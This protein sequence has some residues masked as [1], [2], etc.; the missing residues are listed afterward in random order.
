[1]SPIAEGEVWAYR[2]GRGFMEEVT[3]LKVVSQ[4][5]NSRVRIQFEDGPNAGQT[6]WVSRRMLK[7]RW[8]GKEDF[9]AREQRWEEARNQAA[10]AS[11]HELDAASL[12]LE[13]AL[14]RAIA[15]DH[16]HGILSVRN[17]SALLRTLESAEELP[18][19]AGF[20]E[21]GTLYLPWPAMRVVAQSYAQAKPDRILRE[22]EEQS[23]AWDE[24]QTRR[25]QLDALEPWLADAAPIPDRDSQNLQ[26]MWDL[27][28]EWCGS[29]AADKW[30][31]INRLREELERLTK[32]LEQSL[33]ELEKAGKRY[34][35][36]HLRGQAGPPFDR[37]STPRKKR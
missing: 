17:L 1:M 4:S 18:L 30:R 6:S 8:D 23:A 21:D 11:E 2:R 12:V 32:L 27:A 10:S 25:R 7:T 14:D 35:A 37:P 34:Q 15:A 3:V 31:E 29:A 13:A 26:R 5:G 22:V 28:R 36:S 33:L 19:E 16:N 9:L 24:H 20:T